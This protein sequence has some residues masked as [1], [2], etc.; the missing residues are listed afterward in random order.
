MSQ[1][2]VLREMK[3]ESRSVAEVVR[4]VPAAGSLISIA[5]RLVTSKRDLEKTT[6][7]L[8]RVITILCASETSMILPVDYWGYYCLRRPKVQCIFYQVAFRLVVHLTSFDLFEMEYSTDDVAAARSLQFAKLSVDGYI[9]DLIHT[10]RYTKWTFLLQ[11]H[12]SK[13]KGLYIVTRYLPFILLIINLYMS[14]TPNENLVKCGMLVNI[15]SGFFIIRTYVFWNKNKILLAA[16]LVTYL[17]SSKSTHHTQASGKSISQLCLVGS[18]SIIID[19]TVSAAY[20]TIPIPGV[21]GCY[22]SSTSDQI[23][24]P[25]VIFSVFGLGNQEHICVQ[26]PA[27]SWRRNQSHLY[28][29]L[30]NHNILYYACVLLFSVMNIFTA[31]LLQDSYQT[32]LD[33]I[34]FLAL[35]TVATRMHIHLWQTNQHLRGSSGLVHIRLSDMSLFNVVH[36]ASLGPYKMTGGGGSGRVPSKERERTHVKRPGRIHTLGQA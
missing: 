5:K 18:V 36:G 1:L 30:M 9:L 10:I 4:R 13:M 6:T 33:G 12:W 11:S 25:F 19:T 26:T 28:V 14:F 29:V 2:S 32:V 34:Q 7:E 31:L 24:I 35:A 20:A 22:Q 3:F 21:T 27:D 15:T 8:L 23:F 17:V 16:I